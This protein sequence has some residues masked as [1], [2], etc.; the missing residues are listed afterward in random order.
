MKAP[1]QEPGAPPS[2]ASSIH[3]FIHPPIHP[4]P[5]HPIQPTNHHCCTSFSKSVDIFHHFFGLFLFRLLKQLLNRLTCPLTNQHPEP[6]ATA[7]SCWEKQRRTRE[8]G[9]QTMVLAKEI[10]VAAPIAA[11]LSE[12]DIIFTLEEEKA[13]LKAFL[14]G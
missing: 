4:S 14:H 13:A 8:Y 10:S 11:V 9:L 2:T 12:L 3:P 7:S 5:H 1:V 6:E